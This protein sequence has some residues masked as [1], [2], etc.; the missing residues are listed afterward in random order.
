MSEPLINGKPWYTSRTLWF[1]GLALVIGVAEMQF[2]LLEQYIPA[3]VFPALAF[4]LA[5]TNVLLR[6]ITTTAL[7]VPRVDV[8][9]GPLP[10]A[11]P[12]QGGYLNF[13][14]LL[15]ALRWL[16]LAAVLAW[17][18]FLVYDAGRDANQATWLKKVAAQQLADQA[19]RDR[20]AAVGR[21]AA[22]QEINAQQAEA[23]RNVQL[24][25]V[26]QNA[27]RYF[28]LARPVAL[29]FDHVAR[30]DCRLD[31]Q[32]PA[33]ALGQAPAQQPASPPLPDA[34]GD[35]E[36]TLGAVWLWD[37]AL[38]GQATGTAGAC[39]VDAAT[40]QA[41]AA[42]A[43]SSGLDLDAAWANHSANA[44]T[45]KADRARHQRLIDYLEFIQQPLSK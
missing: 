37:A 9:A 17:G 6:F 30:A 45:C 12:A 5:V 35:I 40:G 20:M 28:H 27:R 38:T 42:C 18:L 10:P 11:P 24:N 36:L 33:S 7:V 22:A 34:G 3:A 14:A 19:E 23:A 26:T 8:T 44:A 41:A 43:D 4:V 15:P 32:P 16:A 1:N 31:S 29:A 25:E 39:R 21:S 13:M 2:K